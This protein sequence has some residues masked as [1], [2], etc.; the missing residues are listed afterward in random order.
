MSR[1]MKITLNQP[2]SISENPTGTKNPDSIY[3]DSTLVSEKNRLFI[4][5]GEDSPLS[6]IAGQI[7]CDAIEKYFHSFLDK[8]QDVTPEFIEKSIRFAEA[9]LDS[10]QKDNPET[11]GMSATLSMLFFAPSCIYFC[12]V[13]KSHIYQIR[14][15]RIVYK[16]IDTSPDRKI[17]SSR[18]PVEVNIVRLKDIR[19][20]DQF[21]IYT[22]ELAD[23]H[24]KE[25]IC[26]VLSQPGSAEERLTELKRIYLNKSK[27]S[28]SAHLIP[29][30][31][32]EAPG[33]SFRRRMNLFMHSFI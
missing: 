20:N 14:G 3:P 21:F 25:I 33:S 28:F 23:F 27:N 4:T 16:S 17:Q 18:K 1:D 6:L 7:I 31:D 19:A 24:D 22:G 13:G 2:F 26:Q 30:R 12:Q 15:N 10:F 32:I 9:S 8:A 29:I 11:R 5:C